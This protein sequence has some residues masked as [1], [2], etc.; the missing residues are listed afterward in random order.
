MDVFT[1]DDLKSLAGRIETPCVS[2][3]IPTH[4]VK[5]EE[6][7]IRWKNHVNEAAKLLRENGIGESEEKELLAEAR[8]KID[9]GD[10]W[11]YQSDGLAGFYAPGVSRLVRTPVSFG[12]VTVVGSHFHVKP[13]LPV[14]RH[15]HRFFLLAL[16]ENAARLFQ[17]N[18]HSI[19][20]IDLE[21]VT[22]SLAEALRFDEKLKQSQTRSQ[23][24]TGVGQGPGQGGDELRHG[25]GVGHDD[26][27]VDR[28]RY[29]EQLDKGL[30]E[31][32]RDGKAPLVLAGVKEHWPIYREANTYPHLLE[33]GVAGNPDR[34]DP[35]TLHAK[36]WPLVQAAFP[37]NSE[38]DA[39]R[40][41]HG[42]GAE[43]G[44]TGTELA[45]A[46]KAACEGRVEV[47]FLAEGLERWGTVDETS[48]EM[49]WHDDRKPT[50]EDLLNVAALKTLAADG[51]VHPVPK[52][53]VPGGGDVAAIYR[54]KV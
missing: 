28:R 39:D 33:E 12:E 10:W 2:I 47:L 48:G 27:K 24:A 17:G 53:D 50:S 43:P 9:D 19:E 22:T 21:G 3:Y 51:T 54:W 29:F 46:V 36:A 41:A 52:G 5:S 49:T 42:A 23:P 34:T 26:V 13:M 14:L 32:L 16:S 8:S 45:E 6:D 7:N 30:H 37:D 4:R 31:Y 20:E 35:N 18:G 25:H 11:N 40:Y 44:T 38:R 1:R 15:N